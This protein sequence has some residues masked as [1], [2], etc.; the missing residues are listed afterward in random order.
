MS[1]LVYGLRIR[2]FFY[3]LHTLV[4][5]KNIPYQIPDQSSSAYTCKQFGALEIRWNADP[6][7]EK[8]LKQFRFWRRR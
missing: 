1:M 8:G 7:K 4:S 2:V 5:I 6:A 3:I